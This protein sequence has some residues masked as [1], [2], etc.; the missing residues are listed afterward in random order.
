M[1]VKVATGLGVDKTENIA[2]SNELR[3]SLLI[4]IWLSSVWVEPPLV[5]GILVVIASDLLLS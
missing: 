5:I 2:V 3:W 1:R 4:I